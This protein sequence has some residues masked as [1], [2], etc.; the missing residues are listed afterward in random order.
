MVILELEVTY[1][2]A[3]LRTYLNNYLLTPWSR[4]ANRFS[5]SQKIPCILWNPMVHYRI[6][7]CPQPVPILSQL[8][9]VHSPTSRFLYIHLNIIL[10]FTPGFPKWSLSLRFPHQNPYTTLLS[11]SYALHTPPIPFRVTNINYQTTKFVRT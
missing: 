2:L 1:L 6:H 4:E 7:K 3:Y 11:H 5:A 10:P 8:D 9:P